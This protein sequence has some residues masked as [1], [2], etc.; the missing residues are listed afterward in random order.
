M[1]I[2]NEI[3]IQKRKKSLKTLYCFIVLNPIL[4]LLHYYY[5]VNLLIVLQCFYLWDSSVV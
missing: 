4:G 5:C 2:N 1:Q 3:K